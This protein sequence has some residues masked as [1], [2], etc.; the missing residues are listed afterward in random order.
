MINV[1]YSQ[2]KKNRVY[3]FIQELIRE[4]KYAWFVNRE[5]RF[6]INWKGAVELYVQ[7][8]A[9]K[10]PGF[11]SSIDRKKA[12]NSFREA[13]LRR[14]CDDGAK[15]YEECQK[16]GEKKKVVEREFQMPSKVF[17]SLFG[18]REELPGDQVSWS[19]LPVNYHV[20]R[21]FQTL[22]W[23]NSYLHE[24]FSVPSI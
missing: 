4:G 1:F 11:D 21:L 23:V 24:N 12:S 13:L 20:L 16:L 6:R 22:F 9:K 8:R 18:S 3:H 19:G 15:E 10:D 5:G 17:H 2:G 14:Y 7:Y